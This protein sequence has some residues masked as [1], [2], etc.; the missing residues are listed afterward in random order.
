MECVSRTTAGGAPP[1][2]LATAASSAATIVS[3]PAPT[4]RVVGCIAIGVCVFGTLVGMF[5]G[6]MMKANC[7]GTKPTTVDTASK[8]SNGV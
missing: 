3:G 2:T 8:A 1:P 7:V 4:T 5:F 6:Y